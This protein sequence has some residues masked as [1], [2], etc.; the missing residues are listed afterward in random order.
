M[1]L[2][3]TD[4]T[5]SGPTTYSTGSYS[6]PDTITVADLNN[7]RRL[8]IIV[9]YF[10]I[11]SVGIFLGTGDGTFVNYT[12]VSTNAARPIWIHIAHLD[13]DTFLDLVTADYGTDSITLYSGDGTGDFS[14]R[15]RYP[16]GF[17]SSPLSV[18]SGDL[19][20]DNHLDLAVA[21]SG[22]NNVGIFFGKGNGEF[23]DQR[24]LSTGIYSRPHS[25]IIGHLDND[26]LL[27]IAIANYGTNNIG[28]FWNLGNETFDEQTTYMLE[29]ASPYFI[30][31]A[32]MNRDKQSDLIVTNIGTNNIGILLRRADGDF[33][34]PK[35]L[36]TGSLSSI[37]AAV[38]DLNKDNLPDIIAISSDTNI[39]SICLGKAEGIQS[40]T[41]YS[42]KETIGNENPQLDITSGDQIE[43]VRR[44]Y[45]SEDCPAQQS[46]VTYGS[47]S[48]VVADFNNDSYPDMAVATVG[49]SRLVVFLGYGNG[50]FAY[51]TT[52]RMNTYSFSVEIADFNVDGHSDI[53]IA[54]GDRDYVSVNIL[55]GC[56]NGS[57]VDPITRVIDD[58]L[59]Q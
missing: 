8:D 46:Y 45:V 50:S 36:V 47:S 58:Q 23:S 57:F 48:V 15:I 2:G 43:R 34:R 20:N 35:M 49:Q 56:G 55:L 39:I 40:E 6:L 25:V 7:D 3:S 52:Y 29:N 41:R 59:D 9:A 30:D 24:V 37:S 28:I 33:A 27:D 42:I 17:D 54:Y 22:T 26:K 14:Y 5:F 11:N 51:E 16:T 38:D 19:N 1:F 12:T 13:N 53:V 21:Y 4:G 18:T 10:G 32:D 31:V 44:Q